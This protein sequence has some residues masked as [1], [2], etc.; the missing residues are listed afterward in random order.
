MESAAKL[1]GFFAAHAVWCVS[2]GATLIPLMG[3]ET[4]DG[5]RQMRRFMA[6]RIEQGVQEGQDSLADKSGRSYA[7]SV[8]L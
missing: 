1:A 2:D 7:S 8:D 6:E 5:Q 4:S 3:V